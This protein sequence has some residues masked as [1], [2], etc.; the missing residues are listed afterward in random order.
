M[1]IDFTSKS[2]DFEEQ[3]YPAQV[4]KCKLILGRD[5]FVGTS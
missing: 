1:I 2:G 5:N 3:E 4:A